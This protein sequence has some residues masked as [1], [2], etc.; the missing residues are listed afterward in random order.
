[1]VGKRGDEAWTGEWV[2]LKMT[3]SKIGQP[4]LTY[5]PHPTAARHGGPRPQLLDETLAGA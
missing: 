5:G 3:D 4:K 1:M 2:V